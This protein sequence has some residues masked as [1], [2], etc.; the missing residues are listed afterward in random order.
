MTREIKNVTVDKISILTDWTS[1]AVPKAETK[2]AL[3]KT[4][5]QY[6]EKA[7]ELYSKVRL[8]KSS[9]GKLDKIIALEKNVI[10]TTPTT[11]N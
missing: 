2:F 7:Q 8:S 6:L 5:K 1:P 4:R 3:F 10:E 11:N 9:K